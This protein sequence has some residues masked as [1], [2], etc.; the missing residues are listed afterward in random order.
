MPDEVPRKW[1]SLE[2]RDEEGNTAL[3]LCTALGHAEG[4]RVLVEAGVDIEAGDRGE[5]LMSSRRE[6]ISAREE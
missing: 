3:G 4:V 5:F 2:A 6:R 1:V